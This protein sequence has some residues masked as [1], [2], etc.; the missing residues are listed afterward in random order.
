MKWI[1]KVCGYIHEGNQPPAICPVC[2]ADS[3]KFEKLEVKPSAASSGKGVAAPA[4]WICKVCGY[5]HEGDTPPAICP[6]CKVDQSHFERLENQRLFPDGHRL[7]LARGVDSRVYQGLKAQCLAAGHSIGQHL[8]MARAAEREG[9]P[10]V[11]G[12][13][14]RVAE[15]KAAHAA[16]LYELLGEGISPDSKD[17]LGLLADNGLA[18]A[19]EANSLAD[20]ARELGLE[21]IRAALSDIARDQARHGRALEGLL[22]R[23]F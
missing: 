10:E 20:L 23:L 9:Y 8:A 2:K 6:V 13:L 14:R 5:V 11:A 15:E 16:R 18:A 17:N 12:A 1:C 7:A 19:L 3:S 22:R 4:R 21:E